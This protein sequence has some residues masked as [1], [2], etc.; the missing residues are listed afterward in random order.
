M[1]Q[2]H[3]K[4]DCQ[5]A[6]FIFKDDGRQEK[7]SCPALADRFDCLNQLGALVSNSMG[8]T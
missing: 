3:G 6:I 4:A 7:W 5:G 2:T 8:D 1:M